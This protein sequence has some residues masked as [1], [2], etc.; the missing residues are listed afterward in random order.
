MGTTDESDWRLSGQERY[1]KGV[2]LVH[3]QY[4]R[5]A[6]N[7]TWDHDHCAFCSVKFMVEDYPGVLRMGYSTTD[8]YHW[9]CENMLRGFQG[10]V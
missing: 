5:N 7:P 8:D 2:A 9:I 1:L 3:C 10:Y 6:K 4:H